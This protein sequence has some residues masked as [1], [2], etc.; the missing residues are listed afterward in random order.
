M[1]YIIE[2]LDNYE[3]DK[4]IATKKAYTLEEL[5]EFYKHEYSNHYYRVYELT[6][7]DIWK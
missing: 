1:N 2:I 5:K 6:N 3:K 7:I 4:V